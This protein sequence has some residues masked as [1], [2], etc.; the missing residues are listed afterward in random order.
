MGQI[1]A[2]RAGKYGKQA[3]TSLNVWSSVESRVAG[4]ESVRAAL[5][6][7]A[8]GEVPLGIVYVTDAMVEPMLS[9][10]LLRARFTA[11]GLVHAASADAAFHS[12]SA[13]VRKVRRVFLDTR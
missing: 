13:A 7:V 9:S 3:L 2:V 12:A 10:L 1:G 11:T 4:A 8:R 6:L 5:A